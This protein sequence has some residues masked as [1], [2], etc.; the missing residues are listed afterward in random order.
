MQQIVKW[1]QGKIVV[2]ESTVADEIAQMNIRRSLTNYVTEKLIPTDPEANYGQWPT[3]AILCAQTVSS[4]G[5]PFQPETARGLRD[6]ALYEAYLKYT[7][8]SA[9]LRDKWLKA[10]ENANVVLDIELGPEPLP[11]SA[12]P[13]A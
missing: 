10:C 8:V 1:A 13:E 12:S 2:R 11:N 6:A 9:A 5:L 7:E 3:F 4:V